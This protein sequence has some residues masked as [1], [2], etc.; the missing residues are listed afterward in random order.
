MLHIDDQIPIV[1]HHHDAAVPVA[2]SRY[3]IVIEGHEK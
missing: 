2:V 1:R 3:T